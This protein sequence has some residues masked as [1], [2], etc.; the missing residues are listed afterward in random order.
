[1]IFNRR[2][3]PYYM[4]QA[5]KI[6]TKIRFLSTLA[7]ILCPHHVFFERLIHVNANDCYVCLL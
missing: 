2:Y 5:H 4:I 3:F 1:M 7:V 6:P